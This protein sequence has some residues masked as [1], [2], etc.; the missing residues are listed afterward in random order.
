MPKL[1]VFGWI[2]DLPDFRDY[3]MGNFTPSKSKKKKAGN[4]GDEFSFLFGKSTVQNLPPKVDLTEYCSPVESQ[5]NVG[6]CTAHAG[7]SLV[8]YYENRNFGSYV[9]AS[10]LFLYKVTRNYMQLTGDTG[11]NPRSTMASMVLFGTPPESHYPYEESQF[12]NEP[13]AFC[14]SFA[15]NYK[16]IKYFRHDLPAANNGKKALLDSVRMAL[17]NGIPSMFGFTVFSSIT[18]ANEQKGAIPFPTPR[19]RR[20]GGHA[21]SAFGY[22]DNI[23]IGHPHISAL[24]KYKGALLIQNSWG[25]SWG[26]KGYGWLPYEYI[27]KGLAVDFWSIIKKEWVN[28]DNFSDIIVN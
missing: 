2:P 24:P 6:S 13:P 22:D 18:S 8:E 5:G 1:P 26:D 19:D 25:L 27:L 17:A 3:S 12:D 14:Y 9:P 4:D 28:T 16:T 23:E 21:V 10:R 11:A 20:L 7:I 15:Q